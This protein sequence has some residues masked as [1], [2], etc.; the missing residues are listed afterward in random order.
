[1]QI[2][3]SKKLLLATAFSGLASAANA[4]YEV[5]LGDDNSITFGGYIKVD[6]RYVD[7]DVGCL[8]FL[9]PYL[10]ISLPK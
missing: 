7:G 4:G 5:K 3:T 10:S 1:M 9:P 8:S 6:A 2:S